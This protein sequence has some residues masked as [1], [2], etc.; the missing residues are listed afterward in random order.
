MERTTSL[1]RALIHWYEA[2]RK[3]AKIRSKDERR[4]ADRVCR[5]ADRALYREV[6][7]RLL[8][9]APAATPQ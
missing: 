5:A 7:C 1:K 6:Q 9:A 4:Q 3:R 2:R 8:R